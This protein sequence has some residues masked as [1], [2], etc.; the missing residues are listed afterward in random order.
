ML[1]G[2]VIWQASHSPLCKE[3]HAGAELTRQNL[4]VFLCIADVVCR[5]AGVHARVA[6]GRDARHGKDVLST[7]VADPDPV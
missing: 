5:V 6:V 4:E 2:E 7:D 1:N 3:L